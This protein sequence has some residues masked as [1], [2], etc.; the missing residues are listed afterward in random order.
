MNDHPSIKDTLNVI[1]RALEEEPNDNIDKENILVL[2]QLINEDGTIKKIIN[3]NIN[4]EEVKNILEK[5]IDNIFDQHLDK[6]LDK[7]IPNYLEK[8]FKNKKN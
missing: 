6:W 5:K 3:D 8:Y 4:K 2:D 1:R 7:N